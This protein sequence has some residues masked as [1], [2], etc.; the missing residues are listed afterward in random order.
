LPVTASEESTSGVNHYAI[1]VLH[2]E[3]HTKALLKSRAAAVWSLPE[4]MP[5]DEL[6]DTEIYQKWMHPRNYEGWSAV[7]IS[8][9]TEQVAI[10]EFFSTAKQLN[11]DD[12]AKLHLLAPHLVRCWK[13]RRIVQRGAMEHSNTEHVARKSTVEP[14]GQDSRFEIAGTGKDEL[15]QYFYRNQYGLTKAE[16]RLA[17]H[18]CC[19]LT[20][21][22]AARKFGVKMSTLRTQTRNLYLK[23]GTV[24]QIELISKLLHDE[25]T[26]TDHQN[27]AVS[28]P[29]FSPRERQKKM[30]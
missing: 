14:G 1:R 26:Y 2:N 12:Y 13:I 3:L 16:A 28:S 21:D 6:G 8:S 29:Q 5:F 22:R 17:D 15:R 27:S 10:L 30:A 20:L 24:R 4:V 25:R 19:G 18:L 7:V 11:S 9:N 23:T